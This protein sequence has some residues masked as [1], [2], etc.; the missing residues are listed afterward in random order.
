MAHANA[1]LRHA[2]L[3]FRRR[4]VASLPTSRY[5]NFPIPLPFDTSTV[6]TIAKMHTYLRHVGNEGNDGHERGDGNVGTGGAVGEA[7]RGHWRV[8]EWR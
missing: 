3:R 5:S 4:S 8:C 6:A 7:S 1:Y 2:T